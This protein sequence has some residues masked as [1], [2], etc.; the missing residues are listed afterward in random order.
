METLQILTMVSNVH[1]TPDTQVLPVFTAIINIAQIVFSAIMKLSVINVLYWW[2]YR[3]KLR[4]NGI[5]L[6]QELF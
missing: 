5:F 1:V 4:N 2:L 6:Q 3:S